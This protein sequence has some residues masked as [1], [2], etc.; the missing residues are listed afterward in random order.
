MGTKLK[1][2][3]SIWLIKF[4]GKKKSE[5]GFSARVSSVLNFCTNKWCAVI[6]E[7]FLLLRG[8]CKKTSGV[9][10][11]FWK[12]HQSL[13]C[14]PWMCPVQSPFQMPRHKASPIKAAQSYCCKNVTGSTHRH[15]QSASW[16][17]LFMDLGHGET[18]LEWF[19]LKSHG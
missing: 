10:T 12:R 8:L 14:S 9:V 11:C 13:D 18:I 7:L 2:L 1:N 16:N 17:I 4:G 5:Q 15:L 3:N 6:L 19:V